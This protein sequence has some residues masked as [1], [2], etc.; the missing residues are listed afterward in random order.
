[1]CD[2]LF[3]QFNRLAMFWKLLLDSS[4]GIIIKQGF[5]VYF[6]AFEHCLSQTMFQQPV[7]SQFSVH[8]FADVT[9]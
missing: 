7:E 4:N 5:Y 8:S 9:W 6:C 3:R 1:M 2:I